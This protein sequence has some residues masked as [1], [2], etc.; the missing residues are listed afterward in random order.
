MIQSLIPGIQVRGLHDSVDT[1][2]PNAGEAET[3]RGVTGTEKDIQH[4]PQASVGAYMLHKFSICIQDGA[5]EF[6]DWFMR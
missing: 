2:H 4:W 5:G 6:H 1:C 3:R